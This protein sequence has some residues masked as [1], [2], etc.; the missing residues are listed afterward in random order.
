MTGPG[1]KARQELVLT[2]VPVTVDLLNST[3]QVAIGPTFVN[4]YFSD[5]VYQV[6][7]DGV[8]KLYGRTDPKR[9]T[10]PKKKK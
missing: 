8:A 1:Y 3:P 7:P 9:L 10:E 6:G 4:K 2:D 5:A